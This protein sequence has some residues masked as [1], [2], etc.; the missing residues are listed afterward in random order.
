MEQVWEVWDWLGIEEEKE[1]SKPNQIGIVIEQ[2]R[3]TR[4]ETIFELQ[5]EYRLM[6][7]DPKKIRLRMNKKYRIN[8]SMSCRVEEEGGPLKFV[9]A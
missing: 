2:V 6:R 3:V 8:V 5:D 1:P 7:Q 9:C 4:A